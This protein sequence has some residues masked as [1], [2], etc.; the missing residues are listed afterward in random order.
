MSTREELK[1]FIETTDMNIKLGPK[2]SKSAFVAEDGT[3][4]HEFDSKS[5][6]DLSHS[7]LNKKTM[8]RC[9]FGSYNLFYL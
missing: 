1:K 7:D 6:I 5:L 3:M 9:F 2:G 8:N 4:R